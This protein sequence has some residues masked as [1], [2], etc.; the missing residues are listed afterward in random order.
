VADIHDM[1]LSV[2]VVWKGRRPVAVPAELTWGQIGNNASNAFFLVQIQEK[3]HNRFKEIPLQARLDNLPWDHVDSLR[4]GDSLVDKG[5]SID[6]LTKYKMGTYRVRVLC[7]LSLCNQGMQN[8]Y[9]DW[10]Y[11]RCL[12]DFL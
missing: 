12:K 10:V 2:H 4:Q 11:F 1:V 6:H 9:S 3:V 5:F 7:N 8:I